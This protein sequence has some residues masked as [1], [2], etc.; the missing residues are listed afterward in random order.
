MGRAGGMTNL[1]ELPAC[2][3][4]SMIAAREISAQELTKACLDQIAKREKDVQAFQFIDPELALNQARALDLGPTTGVLHGLP[5]AVKDIIET[6]DM[7]TG[8]GSQIYEGRMT[9]RDA[10]CVSLCR[11]AGAV[12]LG[13][14]VSSEFAAYSP[15]KTRNPHNLGRTPGASSMGSA[16]G[17]ADFMFPV[18]F[19]SQTASSI[20]RPA[21]H[22]GVVGYK[23]TTGTFSLDGVMELCHSL[24]TLGFIT[25]EIG[26]LSLMRAALLGDSSEIEVRDE[27]VP[28]RFA[29]V[30][31][32]LWPD[33]EAIT[34]KVV[35]GAA[36]IL[37]D[38]G[39]IVEE[40][41]M[42]E[43]FDSLTKAHE[44]I[45]PYE[46]LRGRAYEIRNHPEG[47]TEVFRDFAD[48]AQAISFSE[49][50]AAQDLAIRCRRGIDKIF[51]RYDLFLTPSAVGEAIELGGLT[52]NP[53]FSR[54]WTLLHVPL[55]SL[56]VATGPQGLPVGIQLVGC[57]GADNKLLADA[58]WVRDRLN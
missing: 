15:G 21:A 26:D 14:T 33:A 34:R 6:I 43:G 13:K 55:I 3:V 47:L 10:A 12:I 54:L 30:R 11:A 31:T 9:R 1:N 36:N 7:P 40:P 35:E 53:M 18:G 44:T 51:S 29:L 41:E 4:I 39:A 20:I 50:S 25:R 37:S 23:A 56:P 27:N 57:H 5:L 42:P 2:D 19:G 46:A 49:Y 38:S 52:G 16:A 8:W 45:M 22:C 58:Q 17:V 24:D 28:P 32:N 48:E